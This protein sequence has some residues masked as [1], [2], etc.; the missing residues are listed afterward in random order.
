MC[1]RFNL[2]LSRAQVAYLDE[3][4]TPYPYGESQLADIAPT[5][6]IPMLAS[7]SGAK[8]AWRN[9]RW[10]LTPSWS[11]GPDTT[12]SMFNAKAENLQTSRAFKKPFQ[13]Q[14]CIIPASSYLEWKNVTGG[15]QVMEIYQPDKPLLLAGIWDK[16]H[17]GNQPTLYSCSM[18]TTQAHQQIADIHPRMPIMLNLDEAKIWLGNSEPKELMQ[19]FSSCPDNLSVREFNRHAINQNPTGQQ[20][21]FD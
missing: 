11:Q 9:A 16:W 4:G 10:W 18:V 13:S 5:D 20:G 21:L 15:K 19:L 3:L 17:S 1:G 8:Q 2:L 14:R 7:G 12:F 6:S